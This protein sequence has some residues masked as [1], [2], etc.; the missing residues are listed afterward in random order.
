MKI[1]EINDAFQRVFDYK[2]KLR[3][4][5]DIT[6]MADKL[7]VTVVATGTSEPH[8]KALVSEVQRRTKAS[9]VASYRTSGTPD[10]GWVVVD[11]VH[12]VVHVFSPEA[13]AYYAIEKLWATATEIPLPQS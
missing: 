5:G 6:D 7:R 10:S 2:E 9:D 1:D 3:A 8:L 12:V 11:F 4:S 13:R